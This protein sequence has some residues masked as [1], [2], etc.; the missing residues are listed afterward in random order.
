MSQTVRELNDAHESESGI[1]VAGNAKNRSGGSL[2]ACDDRDELERATSTC[3][4][5]FS[6]MSRG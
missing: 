2:C 4:D 3:Q 5:L 6:A 1:G